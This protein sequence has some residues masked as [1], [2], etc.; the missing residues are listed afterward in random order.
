MASLTTTPSIAGNTVSRT[1]GQALFEAR[2]EGIHPFC[3]TIDEQAGEYLPHRYGAVNY[4]VIDAI[5]HLPL[6]VAD[7]YRR[8]T[9]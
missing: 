6:N 8:L 2:R 4:V 7:T 1:H 9:T 5:R 3:I